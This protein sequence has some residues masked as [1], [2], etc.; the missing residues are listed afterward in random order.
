MVK[1]FFQLFMII[2][3][4]MMERSDFLKYSIVNPFS[5]PVYPV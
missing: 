2:N 5:A 1:E 3:A 4:K